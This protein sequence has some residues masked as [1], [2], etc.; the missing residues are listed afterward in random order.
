MTDM[1]LCL[2]MTM[3]MTGFWRG[4]QGERRYVYLMY[5]GLGIGLLAKGPLILVLAGLVLLPWIVWA[6]GFRRMPG[7]VFRRLQPFSGI[8]LMLV[9]ATP[10]YYLMEQAS[11]G[12]LEYFL[13]G[14]HFQRFIESGWRGDLYGSGTISGPG[15]HERGSMLELSWRGSEPIEL[16]GGEERRFLADGDTVILTGW[17]E[18][19]GIRVGFGEVTGTLLPALG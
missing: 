6:H 13:V 10:W 17:C 1:L 8:L 11:P 3:A 5:A 18:A 12:F 16:P 7:E 9:I 19:D 2:S 4:W 14:E 15:K